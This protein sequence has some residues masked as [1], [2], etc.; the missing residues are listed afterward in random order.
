MSQ[1]NHTPAAAFLSSRA[2]KELTP[3]SSPMD[4]L[5]LLISLQW[6]DE[7]RVL[8]LVYATD[9]LES[10]L[11]KE[12]S[13]STLPDIT[14]LLLLAEDLLAEGHH[15]II[16]SF[17]SVLARF[18][19]SNFINSLP[20][21]VILKIVDILSVFTGK[22]APDECLHLLSCYLDSSDKAIFSLGVQI[23]EKSRGIEHII[24]TPSSIF[25]Q[26]LASMLSAGSFIHQVNLGPYLS[27]A[28][29]FPSVLTHIDRLSLCYGIYEKCL[30]AAYGFILNKLEL[31]KSL[32]T[33]DISAEEHATCVL[34]TLI[35]H[36]FCLNIST[37]QLEFL[38]DIFAIATQHAQSDIIYN[39]LVDIVSELHGVAELYN[40]DQFLKRLETLKKV[41]PTASQFPLEPLRFVTYMSTS[42]KADGGMFY[43]I[44]MRLS[45]CIHKM[46]ILLCRRNASVKYNAIVQTNL[47][48]YIDGRPMSE[49]KDLLEAAQASNAS[50]EI[51]L[52][53]NMR[54][55]QKTSLRK[56]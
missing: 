6:Q 7:D 26:Q 34:N 56:T 23:V 40:E 35:P 33:H 51:R 11:Q 46:E 21:D 28:C 31:S 10:C 36:L 8:A 2:P 17:Y 54:E 3:E 30:K 48:R 5:E 53:V 22:L 19:R 39:I 47:T 18:A 27:S 24:L 41:N 49:C 45:V 29:K 50:Q 32:S 15:R 14:P 55:T 9:L 20:I 16:Q 37:V 1:I 43:I 25:D 38:A 12:S 4:A 13:Q 52:Y 44:L 42:C